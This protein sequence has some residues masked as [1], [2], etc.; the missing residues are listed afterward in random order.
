MI[1]AEH[2][3]GLKN[4]FA[5]QIDDVRVYDRALSAGEVIE[6]HVIEASPPPP[7]TQPDE[8]GG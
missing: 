2:Y 3:G 6:L 4:F 1:G 7:A 8:G 5:G